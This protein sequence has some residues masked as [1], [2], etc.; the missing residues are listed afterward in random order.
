MF[1]ENA[2]PETSR[3]GRLK[4]IAY[5]GKRLSRRWPNL[6]VA[7]VQSLAELAV[8]MKHPVKEVPSASCVET[9]SVEDV[10]A[11]LTDCP[12]SQYF[13]HADLNI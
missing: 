11:V 2:C 10:R 7:E 4:L 9:M 6:C 12:E 3:L 8:A 13:M 5:I 1:V